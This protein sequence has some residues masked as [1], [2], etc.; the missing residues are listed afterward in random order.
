MVDEAGEVMQT[1]NIIGAGRVG[2]TLGFLWHAHEVFAVGAVCA[3]QIDHASVAVQ[4]IKAGV[5]CEM[6][7][8]LSA[9]VWLLTCPDDDLRDCC[10]TLAA[11]GAFT[12]G[13]I[14]LHCSGALSAVEVLQSAADCGAHI[15]SVHPIKS[16]AAPELAVHNFAGT[17]CGVEGD[18][19]ALAILKPVFAA[20]GAVCFDVQS[21][22]K[23]LYHA[24]SVIACNYLVALQE[25]SIQTFAQAGVP[26]EQ[27]MAILQP[28]VSATVGN[29]FKVGT[30]AAL[31]GPI[32]RGDMAVVG[33][34]IDAL[35]DWREDYAQLYEQLARVAVDLTNRD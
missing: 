22:S 35:H 32:A 19:A 18:A 11:R 26:R 1:I 24:A 5:P 12:T 23:T 31:T 2:Q 7:D 3:T 34:Q 17:F 25:V 20:I 29:I 15:A 9:D 10:E 6:V 21:N 16:F 13:S 30:H 8:A 14:V 28:L 4:F 27:A 33:K